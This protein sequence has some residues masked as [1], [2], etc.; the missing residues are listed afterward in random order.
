M[1]VGRRAELALL[2][3]VSRRPGLAAVQGPAGI[4]KSS[5]VRRFLAAHPGLEVRWASGAAAETSLRYGV[6]A[7]LLAGEPP[8]GAGPL[9]AGACLVAELGGRGDV[10][11]VV[12]DAHWADP[13]SLAALAFALRRAKASGVVV[14]PEPG[15]LPEGLGRLLAE[16][17]AV[18][19]RLG[20]LSTANVRELTGLP[21]P[22]ADRLRAHT[23]GNPRHLLALVEQVTVPHLLDPA[24]PLPAP[25][26]FAARVCD[27]LARRGAETGRLVRAAAV[28]GDGCELSRAAEVAGV[29]D[30]LTALEGAA[31]LLGA[32]GA[33]PLIAFADPLTRTAVYEHMGLAVRCR[34]HASAAAGE[35]DPARALAHRAAAVVGVDAGI[36]A[37]LS[38]LASEEASRGDPA[39]A[40]VHLVTAARLTP[41]GSGLS[42]VASPAGRE[43]RLLD[44]AGRFL[45]AGVPAAAAA[46]V[47]GDE[48]APADP[49]RRH[50][51]GRLAMAEGRTEEARALFLDAWGR[52]HRPAAGGLAWLALAE[53]DHAAA[54][55]WARAG[56]PDP[57]LL[58]LAHGLAGRF[59]DAFAAGPGEVV[60][61]VLGLWAGELDG[62]CRDLGPVVNPA[63]RVCLAEAQL[64]LG[65]WDDA[66]VNAETAAD[67]GHRWVASLAHSISA[68]VLARRGDEH[69]AWHAGE[70]GKLA[71]FPVD[72]AFAALARAALAPAEDALLLLAPVRGLP[73]V[74]WREPYTEALIAVGEWETAAELLD[75]APGRLRGMLAAARGER[76]A[77]EAAFEAA[78]SAGQPSVFERA[79]TH[80]EYGALLR[81]SAA[82]R[83]AAP[84]LLAAR[85]LFEQ[86][87]AVPGQ[88]RC[89]RELAA[90]GIGE[91][92]G[93]RGLT[94]QET[95]V[96]GLVASGLTNRQVARELVL[97]V[98]TVEYHLGHVYAKL[99]VGSRAQLAHRFKE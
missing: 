54:L 18:Q 14:A 38:A 47:M 61:G 7:Q 57:D 22:V 63:A 51:M 43:A 70:A 55:T 85:G 87:G 75:G 28:L 77:A 4:G 80:L 21:G 82:R 52:G 15:D 24:R 42:L 3:T 17:D 69:A 72:R 13:A 11:V 95:T 89:R 56:T 48:W 98:K 79:L 76:A 84:H 23:L 30:P 1:F 45:D 68:R 94:P 78:L 41:H 50:V 12:D 53:G 29:A 67:S 88:V 66:L 62:V 46:L 65:S 27:D 96:A 37:E 33:G 9:T 8:A 10:V 91:Q 90:C 35:P 58:A 99:G 49:V 71:C 16:D 92:T 64:R 44:A 73:G 32:A 40:A 86:L 6:L 59:S 83:L 26:E 36:A 81:R 93:D 60:R 31:G 20:G 25:K 97:S 19:V 34:L 74:P 2:D 5:L 39:Q